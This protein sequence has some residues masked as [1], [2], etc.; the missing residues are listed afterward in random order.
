MHPVGGD[1]EMADAPKED[2]EMEAPP[3][4]LFPDQDNLYHYKDEPQK[5]PKD[6]R[7]LDGEEMLSS[8][9]SRQNAKHDEPASRQ[10]LQSP[11]YRVQDQVQETKEEER[12]R[13]EFRRQRDTA[14]ALKNHDVLDNSRR[15]SS[16]KRERDAS[17]P[18]QRSRQ[19]S[20]VRQ[21]P[22]RDLFDDRTPRH[23]QEYDATDPPRGRPRTTREPSGKYVR[24]EESPGGT[25]RGRGLYYRHRSRSPEAPVYPRQRRE[26]S[27]LKERDMGRD[28]EYGRDERGYNAREPDYA[29]TRAPRNKRHDDRVENRH[30]EHRDEKSDDRHKKGRDETVDDHHKKR[31][32]EPRRRVEPPIQ[33]AV[34]SDD[35]EIEDTYKEDRRHGKTSGRRRFEQQDVGAELRS[36][37]RSKDSKEAKDRR[38]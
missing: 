1:C 17:V 31:R 10:K 2:V 32:D 3:T 21:K 34:L 35:R 28:E 29:D 13:Q 4:S 30:E 36:Y 14:R 16:V 12:A 19:N 9:G 27:P 18:D 11:Q 26:R 25:I 20:P 38:R 37:G 23:R 22:S 7:F 8:H 15:D 6:P 5:R 24:R 33:S